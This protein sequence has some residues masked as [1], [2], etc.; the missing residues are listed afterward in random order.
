MPELTAEVHHRD[1]QQNKGE[2]QLC[3]KTSKRNKITWCTQTLK[4]G[5]LILHYPSY[6]TLT[7][8]NN[9]PSS[10]I[11]LCLVQHCPPAINMPSKS[12]VLKRSAYIKKLNS[13]INFH[14]QP[15]SIFTAP[16]HSQA[17]NNRT[18]SRSLP[19]SLKHLQTSPNLHTS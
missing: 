4:E 1:N 7:N 16:A 17:T 13:F 2:N 15:L 11:L 12:I 14:P 3:H 18:F 10:A 6:S 9:Q 19:V 8:S 5:I